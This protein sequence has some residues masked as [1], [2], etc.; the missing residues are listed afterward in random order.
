MSTWKIL[1][2]DYVPFLSYL[3]KKSV[4]YKDVSEQV[5]KSIYVKAINVK[6]YEGVVGT[7]KVHVFA[8]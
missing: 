3:G 1:L 5:Y 7:L 8:E 6:L 2:I 4:I